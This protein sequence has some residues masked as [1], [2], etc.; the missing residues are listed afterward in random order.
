MRKDM[1]DKPSKISPS[2]EAIENS[3]SA[4]SISKINNLFKPS[5]STSTNKSSASSH[6]NTNS[7][8]KNSTGKNS[9]GKNSMGKNSTGRSSTGKE[10]SSFE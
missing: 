5:S 6:F 4:V 1:S 2:S 7:M 8:G 3:T 9:T 10:V